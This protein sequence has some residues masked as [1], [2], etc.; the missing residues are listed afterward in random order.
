MGF[1]L[2]RKYTGNK[3]NEIVFPLG[4]IGSGSVGIDGTGR[5]L[6]W[7]I[8]NR[9]AKGTING[10]SHFGIKVEENGHLLSAKVMNSDLLGSRSGRY[11]SHTKHSGYGYG[12]F[13][14]Q[15]CGLP[16][17]RDSE[18]YGEYPLAA[19]N[20][21]DEDFPG[22]VSLRA[23]NPFI[24]SNDKDSS[25]PAA[26]FVA[27]V[28]NNT[29]RTLTYTFELSVNNPAESH[30]IN[31]LVKKDSF[32]GIFLSDDNMNSEDPNYGGVAFGTPVTDDLQVQQY[33][34]RGAWF[35]N[36]GVFWQDFTAEKELKNR[37]Y[38][39][40]EKPIDDI[41]T[42][43]VKATVEPG[44]TF[45]QKFIL[46]WYYP[47]AYNYWSPENPDPKVESFNRTPW[48]NYYATIFSSAAD[49]AEYA[50]KNWDR[51]EK[52]TIRFHDALY[53]STL[54]DVALEAISANMAILK[55][56]TVLRLTDGQFYG[57]EGT[58]TNSGSCEG[59]C[60]HVWNYAFALPFLFPSLERSMR[61]LDYTYN[62]N[63]DGGMAFR[64]QLPLGKTRSN[65]RPCVD[66]QMGGIIKTYREWKISGNTEWLKRW[67]PKV[68]SSLEYA[69]NP[70]SRE[71]WDPEKKGYITGRQHHTLDMELFGPDA[72][73]NNFYN[74]A[75]LAAAEMAKAVGDPDADTYIKLADNC[76][77]YTDTELFNGEY[78]YQ[79]I[80][81]RDKSI[82]EPYANDMALK[83]G[84]ILEAYWNDEAKQIKYQI[85]EG[86]DID[87]IFAQL[88]C[89]LVG[90]GE[91]LNRDNVNTA[92]NSIYKYNY[93][94]SMRDHYNPCRI[95][96]MN[97]ESGMVIC[98][99]PE[100][101]EKPI[102]PVPYSE[103]TM[104][105]FEY[106]AAIHMIMHDM[107]DKGLNVIKSIRDRYDGE[108]RNPWGEFECGSNYARSMVSYALLLAYSGFKYDMC[109]KKMGMMP[110]HSGTYFWALD[111][112]WGLMTCNDAG[113]EINVKYGIINI[114]ELICPKTD[115]ISHVY[116]N[117]KEVDFT[118]QKDTVILNDS[119]ELSEGDMLKAIV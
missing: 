34:Y 52:Q 38:E 36:L 112:A 51:L 5:F 4:G 67:W 74:G 84:T 16:H 9:P 119:I 37:I 78:Y 68:K 113:A 20:F 41:A 116:H 100:G 17:F 54:P 69:W 28:S 80:D 104:H 6:D 59:S 25:L 71:K 48:K 75:L 44:K 85:A 42:I 30:H 8:F 111:G 97:D 70:E 82:L 95:F 14:S 76:R 43:A 117:S 99:W 92:L 46:T 108:Y 10:N 86:C 13:I 93:K 114:K 33:W 102:I 106:Q 66:G 94:P 27:E 72:W 22:E 61:E 29:D 53:S 58:Q 81:I 26:F 62:M 91:Y 107:E 2:K 56:S 23:F 110:L 40:T 32:Q 35:D 118:V 19:I 105:G 88:M 65:F 83:G 115:L 109:E 11:V 79:K 55:S 87:Q 47:N 15:L 31:N 98:E 77:K 45:S 89:E 12:P 7:E 39:L 64:L 101:K 90:I 21:I 24:P 3:R 103:E 57:F 50:I 63:N 73:L 18:F 60:T 49:V 1:C 96:S